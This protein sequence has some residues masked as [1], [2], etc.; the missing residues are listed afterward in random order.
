MPPSSFDDLPGPSDYLPIALRK[1]KKAIGCKWVFFIKV[2]LDG[3]VARLKARLV[4]K[5]YA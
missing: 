4:A 1:G 5:G 3:I 2:N